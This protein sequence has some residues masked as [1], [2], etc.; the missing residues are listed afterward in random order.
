MTP[1]R[2]AL[3]RS[4][5]ARDEMIC[6]YASEQVNAEMFARAK[7]RIKANGGTLADIADV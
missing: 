7:S 1:L 6:L 2:E 5:L 3:E 4:M